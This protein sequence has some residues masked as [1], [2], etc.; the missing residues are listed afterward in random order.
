MKQPNGTERSAQPGAAARVQRRRQSSGPNRLDAVLAEDQ[1]WED[2]VRQQAD[3]ALAA[4]RLGRLWT[5]IATGCLYVVGS[6]L[7]VYLIYYVVRYGGSMGQTLLGH[8]EQPTVANQ[9]LA[10][11]GQRLVAVSWPIILMFSLALAC[12]FF[13]LML[14]RR[15]GQAFEAN[16]ASISRVRREA[17]GRIARSPGLTQHLAGSLGALRHTL[18]WSLW[19]SKTLFIVGLVLFLIVLGQVLAGSSVGPAVV[20]LSAAAVAALAAAGVTGL[21][22]RLA[23]ALV[24]MTELEAVLDGYTREASIVEEYLYQVIEHYRAVREPTEARDAVERGVEQLA[25]LL[26]RAARHIGEVEASEGRE[27]RVGSIP[28]DMRR[29]ADGLVRPVDP[30]H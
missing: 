2:D 6:G 27:R 22:R 7:L 10:I 3:Q 8:T 1:A 25:S 23:A 24:R 30:R 17:T 5:T 21:H 26:A 19:V 18:S 20:G 29:P 9:S 11:I 15:S 28:V 12:V 16:L 4:L 14:Q 13:A